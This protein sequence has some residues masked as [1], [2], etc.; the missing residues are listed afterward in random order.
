MG[1]SLTDHLRMIKADE[2]EPLDVEQL[3]TN[4]DLIDAAVRA[5]PLGILYSNGAENL[6]TRTSGKQVITH[7]SSF[8]FKKGRRYLIVTEGTAYVTNLDTYF[9]I[10]FYKDPDLSA[11]SLNQTGLIRLTS[12][13]SSFTGKKTASGET[14]SHWEEYIP[15]ANETVQPKMLMERVAG[16]GEIVLQGF[17]WFIE[18]KGP[19]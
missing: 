7:N 15:A 1:T 10:N 2:N 12:R 19:A 13:S 17:M 6:S 3:N 8:T 18:D 5:L 16:T 9:A 14:F 4:F 11:S